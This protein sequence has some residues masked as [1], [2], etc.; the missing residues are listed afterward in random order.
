MKESLLHEEALDWIL[1]LFPHWPPFA[2]IELSCPPTPFWT[3]P[4]GPVSLHPFSSQ[5]SLT[6]K[7][8]YS[9]EHTK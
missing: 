5:R 7:R 1:S 3:P 9:V 6:Q 4:V 8:R 2:L